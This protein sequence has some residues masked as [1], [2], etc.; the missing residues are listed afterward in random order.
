M[1][2]SER[3][4]N[5][6]LI[7]TD[8]QR[9]DTIRALGYPW[10]DTPNLDR[11]VDEGVSFTNHFVTAA[12]CSPSRAS[13]FTGYYPHTTGIYQNADVWKH[14][15]VENLAD[16]GYHCVNIGKMHTYPYETPL[17]FHERFVVENKDRYLEGRWFFD[18]WDMAFQAHG[19]VKQQRELY[20]KLP[21]YRDLSRRIRMENARS[22]STRT[23]SSGT[24]RTGGSRRNRKWTSRSSC[25]SGSPGSSSSLRSAATLR[26]TVSREGLPHARRDGRGKSC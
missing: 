14:S 3:R 5:I 26:R 16:A 17:G 9:Y 12:S 21:D 6:V 20:R 8:Q 4:P 24:W 22:T 25:R 7:I 15:W 10:M 2:A 1:P 18:R 19:L 11:L 23:S 13:F